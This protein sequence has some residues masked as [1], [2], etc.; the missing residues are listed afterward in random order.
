MLFRPD[1]ASERPI[2]TNTTGNAAALAGPAVEVELVADVA[3]P[4]GRFYRHTLGRSLR[5]NHGVALQLPR[6]ACGI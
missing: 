1:L 2:D 6:I 3:I 5:R 4:P